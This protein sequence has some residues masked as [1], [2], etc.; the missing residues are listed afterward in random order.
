MPRKSA[1]Q[2]P[3][4]P[5]F[6]VEPLGIYDLAQLRH[7][8]NLAKGTLGREIR[9]RRLRVA[10]RGGRRFIL[11]RWILEWLEGGELRSP[12]NGQAANGHP[13]A[14][15]AAPDRPPKPDPKG[16]Q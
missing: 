12:A 14:A 10:A 5:P 16:A 15:E 3:P 1:P 9:L 6:V 7:G 13:V 11:G 2:A 4:P 8:L